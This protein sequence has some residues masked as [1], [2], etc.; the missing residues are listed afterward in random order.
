MLLKLTILFCGYWAFVFCT[1]ICSTKFYGPSPIRK[2]MAV[3]AGFIR[4]NSYAWSSS[5]AKQ[6]TAK[7]HFH[8][9]FKELTWSSIE[10]WLEMGLEHKTVEKSVRSRGNHMCNCSEAG[11]SLMWLKNCKGSW[12][13]E[14]S[15]WRGSRG[16]M[17][18]SLAKVRRLDLILSVKGNT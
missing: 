2:V 8:K 15:S 3:Q 16:Q 5:F 14:R 1:F 18:Q 6:Q 7:Q 10:E 11:R 9:C 4:A 12:C 13:I 17:R